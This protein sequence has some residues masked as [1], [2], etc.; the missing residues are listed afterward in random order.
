MRADNRK[1]NTYFNETHNEETKIEMGNQRR[2]CTIVELYINLHIHAVIDSIILTNR[3]NW[4]KKTCRV[5]ILVVSFSS[6]DSNIQN[7]PTGRR[8]FDLECTLDKSVALVISLR[9]SLSHLLVVTSTLCLSLTEIC[10]ANENIV[11]I[12]MFH[13][14]CTLHVHNYS[15]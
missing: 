11:K 7:E 4:K 1:I 14:L 12:M 15:T 8:R 3:I 2:M 5:H 6:Y 10:T 13:V 9:L